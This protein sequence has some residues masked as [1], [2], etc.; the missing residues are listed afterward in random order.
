M[1]EEFVSQVLLEVNGKSITDFK[2]VEEKEYEIHKTVNLMNNTGHIRSKER[3]G[4]SL[5]YVIPKDT[6]PFDF[7]KVANGKIVID[8]QSGLRVNYGGVYVT[9]IGAVKHDGDKESTKTID[10]SA[11]T[12]K[13]K[14]GL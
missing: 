13:E 9:K 11:K 7:E 14:K 8:Y 6:T 10:F 2:S 3:H 5:E 12:R 4:V 1:S